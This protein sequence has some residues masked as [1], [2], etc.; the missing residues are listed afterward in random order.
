VVVSGNLV[1]A[2]TWHDNAPFMREFMKML[3]KVAPV[4]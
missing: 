1:T 2:R 4:S 3:N